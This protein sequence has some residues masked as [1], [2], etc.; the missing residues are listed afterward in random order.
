MG[1]PAGRPKIL[2]DRHGELISWR[3]T[4]RD[5]EEEGMPAN[6][7]D[8]RLARKFGRALGGGAHH[9]QRSGITAVIAVQS[10]ALVSGQNT[11]FQII[12][13]YVSTHQE[14]ECDAFLPHITDR[15]QA[16]IDIS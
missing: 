6:R 3:C 4:R 10:N 13:A 14:L 8:G 7:N 16:D 2:T 11:A 1:R 12:L 5:G 9:H 15:F